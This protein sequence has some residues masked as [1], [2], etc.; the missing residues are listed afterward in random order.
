MRSISVVAA[1]FASL[2]AGG[3]ALAQE[4]GAVDFTLEAARA[5]Y[6]AAQWPQGARR[7]GFVLEDL[8]LPG[9]TGR[10]CEFRADDVARHY[11]DAKGVDRVLIEMTV[12]ET[13][14]DAHAVLLRHVA[15][16]QSTKTL[17]TAA[18]RGIRA[19]DVGYVGNGG[20]DGSKIAWLAFVVGNL[21]FRV[22]NLAPDLDGA[23]DPK[24]LVELLSQRA[25]AQ[26]PLAEGVPV[27]K[28]EVKDFHAA[29]P[30][31]AAGDS[32]VL[33]VAATDPT[34]RAAQ[35]DFVVGGA[36]NGAGGQ[37]YVEPDEQGRW[38]FFATGAGP[39]T[40]TVRVLGRNGTIATKDFAL[41]ITKQ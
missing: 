4:A 2:V 25:T 6:A 12:G 8:A 32:I 10:D 39:A 5:K 23:P 29:Q 20:K 27:P 1:V 16:V 36:Q 37:G 40:L 13:A 9:L 35:F 21:E 24:P 38:R 19:G 11:A 15:Y 26:S 34:G 17:P 3:F 14:A 30:T 7:A 41:T 18:A 33:D 22:V 28:P 31:V